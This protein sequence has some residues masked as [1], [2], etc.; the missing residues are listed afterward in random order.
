M[1]SSSLP[2]SFVPN[3]LP[4]GPT[5]TSSTTAIGNFDDDITAGGSCARKAVSGLTSAREYAFVDC[6]EVYLAGKRS[7]GIYEIW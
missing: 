1:L 2:P 7:S 4:S 5:T 3:S 6:S